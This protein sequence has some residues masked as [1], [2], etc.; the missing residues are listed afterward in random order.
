MIEHAIA[1]TTED[2]LRTAMHAL[3]RVLLWNHY[4]I[5]LYYRPNAWLAYWDKFERPE[6]APRYE[7]GI[8]STWWAKP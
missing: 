4:S 3:D 2:A 7:L 8:S 5:P 1:A 6:K